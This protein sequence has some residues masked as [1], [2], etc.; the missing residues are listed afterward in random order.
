MSDS[1][2]PLKR[3][4]GDSLCLTNI[5][6]ICGAPYTR[7]GSSASVASIGDR[8][9]TKEAVFQKLTLHTVRTNANAAQRRMPRR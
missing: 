6:A 5:I 3:N 7:G 1:R 2:S 4:F 8:A 9:M